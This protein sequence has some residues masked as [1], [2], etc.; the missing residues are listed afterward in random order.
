MAQT[1]NSFQSYTKDNGEWRVLVQPQ[2]GSWEVKVWLIRRNG[3]DIENIT[4]EKGNF[5]STVI[6]DDGNLDLPCFLRCPENVWSLIV[7]ALTNTTTPVKQEVVDAK[8]ELLKNHLSDMRKI[9]SKK[10]GVEL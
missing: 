7:E 5:I 2:P 8:I 1:Y 3:K 4:V 6:K 9:V 10:I